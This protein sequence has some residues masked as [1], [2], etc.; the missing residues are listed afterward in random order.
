MKG[1]TITKIYLISVFL[2]TSLPT[3]AQDI[4]FI[5][6][7]AAPLNMNP[8]FTGMFDGNIRVS[9]IY[10]NYWA[11]ASLPFS[12]YGLSADLPVFTDQ[13]GNYLSTGVQFIRKEAGELSIVNFSGMASLAY[14]KL[15][16][17]ADSGKN[18]DLAIG[19]QGT[20]NQNSID[21]SDINYGNT[22]FPVI[23]PSSQ[24]HLGL[25][26]T[27]SNYN[28]NGGI[29]FSQ[30]TGTKFS[31]T[32]GVSANNLNQPKD[33]TERQQNIQFGLAPCY[34]AVLGANWAVINRLTLRPAILYESINNSSYLIAG[35]EFQYAVGY[36]SGNSFFSSIFAG[37]WYRSN[38][39][40]VITAGTK[41]RNIRLGIGYDL[42][43][44]SNISR[45]MEIQLQY[46]TPRSKKPAAQK[47][48]VPC[49]RF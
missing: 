47:R 30:A 20:Y 44:N 29:S 28:I 46:I 26:N 15:F 42:G 14:H 23:Y 9:G 27:I 36:L 10:Q 24:Y 21:L 13:N 41:F 37:G 38:D 32:V 25:G 11:N 43:I 48:I 49:S 35:N 17:I 31:Y 3:I 1:I 6:F 2:C 19:I 12:T 8:T 33:Q 39:N 18:C 45:G 22:S 40:L 16:S 7:D 34:R 4:H 5:P